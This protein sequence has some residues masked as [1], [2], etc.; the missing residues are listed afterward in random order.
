MNFIMIAYLC[1][2]L[3]MGAFDILRQ[4]QAGRMALAFYAAGAALAIC[5]AW[6]GWDFSPSFTML[7]LAANLSLYAVGELLWQCAGDLRA[8]EGPVKSLS[9]LS[10]SAGTVFVFPAVYIYA[11]GDDWLN[12][13]VWIAPLMGTALLIGAAL[14]C[15]RR[16]EPLRAGAGIELWLALTAGSFALIC[17]IRSTALLPYG[18]G[19]LLL[20]SARLLSNERETARPWRFWAGL[21]LA[22]FMAALPALCQGGD[23]V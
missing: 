10:F 8:W 11:A 5:A 9:R 6:L 1:S 23:L 20:A 19:L 12:H 2:I 15:R 18:A 22:S 13:C 14:L 4:K 17:G 3:A 7:F 16:D 21:L